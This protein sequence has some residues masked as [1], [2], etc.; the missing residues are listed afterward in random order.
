MN[1]HTHHISHRNKQLLPIR[2]PNFMEPSVSH[3]ICPLHN[4]IIPQN[5]LRNRYKPLTSRS[6]KVRV[7]NTLIACQPPRIGR[8]TIIASICHCNAIV[9]LT[10]QRVQP[11]VVHGLFTLFILCQHF[12][13]EFEQWQTS[14][15]SLIDIDQELFRLLQ[16]SAKFIR[17]GLRGNG[18][19]NRDAQDGLS[20]TQATLGN[21]LIITSIFRVEFNP[22]G[23]L[24]TVLLGPLFHC[25][26]VTLGVFVGHVDAAGGY[27]HGG[28]APGEGRGR[29][30]GGGTSMSVLLQCGGGLEGGGCEC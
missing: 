20:R 17:H 10:G 1:L 28:S 12:H 30:D 15:C 14:L 29:S 8:Q 21:Q 26:D 6:S 18:N 24:G 23:F 11:R 27:A 7:V 19:V 3:I 22:V 4:R 25:V 2:L 16:R 13:H 9:K 5:L